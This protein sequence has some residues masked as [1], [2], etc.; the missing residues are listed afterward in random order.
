M[1][2]FESLLN[3]AI[4]ALMESADQ[5]ETLR[6]LL[7]HAAKA[8]RNH[9]FG[10]GTDNF[11][12]P[13]L[14]LADYL[15]RL[16]H[17]HEVDLIRRTVT[18]IE[19]NAMAFAKA[20]ADKRLSPLDQL[21]LR[22]RRMKAIA[23]VRAGRESDYVEDEPPL[24]LVIDSRNTGA[25]RRELLRICA[26]VGAHIGGSRR[27]SLVM[28]RISDI[29]PGDRVQWDA[30]ES[31]ETMSLVEQRRRAGLDE[32]G[33]L[34]F[35]GLVEA[36]DWEGCGTFYESDDVSPMDEDDTYFRVKIVSPDDYMGLR[37][38]VP[39]GI[40]IDPPFT[41]ARLLGNVHKAWADE[42]RMGQWEPSVG[43]GEYFNPETGRFTDL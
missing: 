18:G 26:V 11:Y 21:K 31:P 25:N 15:E 41:D 12:F 16:G 42:D 28:N 40:L 23:D 29:R 30:S 32:S 10:V 2:Q 19:N 22:D 35:V 5:D 3:K 14:M 33:D 38:V 13:I 1:S 7:D 9:Q 27:S 37:V 20:V 17:M 36:T 24:E 39:L 6:Q 34:Q 4:S 8:Y 43:R